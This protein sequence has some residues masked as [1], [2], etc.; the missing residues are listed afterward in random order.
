MSGKGKHYGYDEYDY[1]QFSVYITLI[2]YV[3]FLLA[4]IMAMKNSHKCLFCKDTMV[5]SASSKCYFKDQFAATGSIVI[6]DQFNVV[7]NNTA[8]F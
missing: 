6:L 8:F 2:V 4:K 1:W 5:A 3:L 7:Y